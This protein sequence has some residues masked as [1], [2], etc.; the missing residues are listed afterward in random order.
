ML[1]SVMDLGLA[2][3]VQ[4][5][6]RVVWGRRRVRWAQRWMGLRP[7]P[8][9]KRREGPPMMRLVRRGDAR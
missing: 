3:W 8:Q 1:Y 5:R 7:H 2:L 4:L 9:A 6:A